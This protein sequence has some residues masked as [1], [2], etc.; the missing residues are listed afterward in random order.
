MTT[1]TALI[2]L[3]L[4]LALVAGLG[5][6]A[7]TLWREVRRRRDFRDE[8]RRRAH[9]NCLENLELVASALLQEQVDITEGAWRCKVLL[10]IL[11]PRLIERPD[12]AAFGEVHG[13]TRHLHTHSARQALSPRE[14]F[15]ED[16]ERLAVE[17]E[18]REPILKAAA[19]AVA[20]RRD[21]LNR[22]Y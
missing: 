8:E 1:T 10:E 11:D 21:R 16:R 14:R 20:F 5:A 18:L 6:Y 19:A 2:L 4:A 12:F 13:R 7:V 9:D 17:D 15:Q 3:G 22:S